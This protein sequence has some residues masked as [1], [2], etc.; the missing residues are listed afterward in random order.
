M[1]RLARLSAMVAARPRRCDPSDHVVTVVRVRRLRGGLG[2][3][4]WI[5][6]RR[7]GLEDG[8]YAEWQAA[9]LDVWRQQIAMRGRS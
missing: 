8:P 9:W 2:S 5:R 3:R 6:C 1:T 7:C 4:Y